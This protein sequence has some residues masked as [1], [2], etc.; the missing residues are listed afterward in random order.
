MYREFFAKS[1]L[2]ALPVASLV[3][4]LAVFAAV[5]LAVL[6]RR[7]SHFDAIARMPLEDGE[8]RRG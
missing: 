4:F 6:R 3:I 2:L 7:A 1:P 5:L 8:V